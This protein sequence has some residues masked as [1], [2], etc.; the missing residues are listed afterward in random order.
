MRVSLCWSILILLALASCTEDSTVSSEVQEDYDGPLFKAIPATESGIA[1]ANTLQEDNVFNYFTYEYAYNGAGVAVGDFNNDGFEDVYLTGNQVNDAIYF[2]QQNNTFKD[3]SKVSILTGQ[4]GWHTGV[5]TADVNADGHLDIYVCR[6]GMT[7]DAALLSNLLY[8]NN[9]DGTFA[10]KATEYGLAGADYS[11]QAAFFDGDADGDLDCYVLNHPGDFSQDALQDAWANQSYST[12]R[13]YRNDNGL[14]VDHTQAA[15]VENHAFGLGISIGDINN[16]HLPDLYIANDFDQGDY[17]Y[18]NQGNGTF[19]NEIVDRFKHTSNSGMGTDLADFNNDGFPDLMELDM[20]YADHVLSKTNM[21][22]MQPEKFYALAR[23]GNN[24]QYMTNSLQMNAGNGTFSEIGQMAGVAKTNWSWAPLFADF[25]NDGFKDLYITNG[26]HRD[27]NNRDAQQQLEEKIAQENEV[28]FSEIEKLFPTTKVSNVAY[29]NV[30][31]LSF[32][33]TNE[34][35]GLHEQLNSNGSAY[36]DFDNDGDL[37]I[38]VNNLDATAS[39]FENQAQHEGVDYLCLQLKGSSKNP[40]AIGAKVIVDNGESIQMAELYPTR[41]YQSAVSHRIH[42]AVPRVAKNQQVQ[43]I[44]PDGTQSEFPLDQAENKVYTVEWQPDLANAT[45]INSSNTYFKE[46][47]NKFSFTYTHQENSYSDY[48]LEVLLPHSQSKNG[49]FF[50]SAD[51]TG[52]GSEA[53]YISG[54][55]GIAGTLIVV[56][57]HG[58]L[59]STNAAV[60]EKDK[61][62]EDQQSLFFDADNDGD[63]DLYIVS[64]GNEITD[65]S[66]LQDRLYLNDGAGNFKKTNGA[67]PEM[68]SSGLSVCAADVN[69]DGWMDLFVGGRIVPQHYPQSPQSYLL[70]NNKGTFSKAALPEPLANAGMVTR[71]AFGDM[72]ADGDPDLVI[73][74]EWMAPSIWENDGGTFKA[75]K[76][77]EALKALAGLYFGLEL[78]DRDQDGDLDILLGNLGLNKKFKA[79]KD[80]PFHIY[81]NDFDENGTWDMAMSQYQDDKLYPVRGRECS[82]EQMPFI[83]EQFPTYNAFAQAE[84]T[85]ILPAAKMQN[86]VHKEIY[87]F[88]SGWLENTDKGYIFHPFERQMQLSPIYDFYIMD[89]NK[90]QLP[91]IV[92]AGNLFD[93]EVETVRY[94]ASYGSVELQTSPGEYELQSLQSSGFFAAGNVRNL[95]LWS[96]GPNNIPFLLVGNNSQTMQVFSL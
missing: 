57:P 71:S 94:D 72:D 83:S 85:S 44:W 56:L 86:A 4:E 38:V 8:I 70:I 81:G 93:V 14:Y 7:T 22:S 89:I 74:G 88:E 2:N 55:T 6:S 27:I 11:T 68:P 41:G 36:A 23:M 24:F 60:F 16:D 30:G 73:V 63:Q 15:G 19:K 10:E 40:G 46:V 33:S 45:Q 37:D 82:S 92:T 64:G 34:A 53:L 28:T 3:V 13:Y 48:D 21:G 58:S 50:A 67:L 25:D 96:F 35:W 75:S 49:P 39:F 91:D 20:A 31:N 17:C 95:H 29:R 12:D 79:S 54:A 77:N 26:F 61:A 78:M 66:L 59:A 65:P 9:G 32:E 52:D 62:C 18:I 43:V 69:G 76:N 84:I 80:H 51:I 87:N 90:D 42:M 1:F 47:T 5:T